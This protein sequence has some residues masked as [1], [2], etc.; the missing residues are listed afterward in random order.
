MDTT[1][2]SG[3]LPGLHLTID[4]SRSEP[5]SGNYPINVDPWFL[6]RSMGAPNPGSIMITNR[7][8]IGKGNQISPVGAT[9]CLFVDPCS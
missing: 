8:Q 4:H 7:V 1:P 5:G 6:A 9:L 3:D 2:T